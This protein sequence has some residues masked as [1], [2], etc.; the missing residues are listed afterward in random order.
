MRQLNA[1]HLLSAQPT[2][3]H[4]AQRRRRTWFE[5][6]NRHTACRCQA[7]RPADHLRVFSPPALDDNSCARHC[8]AYNLF[9]H[10]YTSFL[11]PCQEDASNYT[12][13]YNSMAG[14]RCN[15]APPCGS[16]G[17]YVAMTL[18]AERRYVATGRTASAHNAA[19]HCPSRPANSDR[20]RGCRSA[21]AVQRPASA[22]LS[23]PRRP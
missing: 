5:P 16:V 3:A 9:K 20:C 15:I 18:R 12:A 13:E 21:P 2:Q 1:I 6:T 10:N 19:R 7:R 11:R 17:T 22:H 8:F 14:Q 4:R 23:Q